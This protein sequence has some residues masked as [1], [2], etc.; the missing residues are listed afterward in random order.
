MTTTLTSENESLT[1]NASPSSILCRALWCGGGE[2]GLSLNTGVGIL[3]IVPLASCWS[4]VFIDSPLSRVVHCDMGVENLVYLLL[5][6][7]VIHWL[8]SLINFCL[9][10]RSYLSSL[11]SSGDGRGEMAV[12]SQGVELLRLGDLFSIFSIDVLLESAISIL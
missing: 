5:Q 3:L 11:S 8:L 9:F 4:F 6:E 2:F 7:W 12:A 1:Q 10:I